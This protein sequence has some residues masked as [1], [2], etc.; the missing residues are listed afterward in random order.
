MATVPYLDTVNS[1]PNNKNLPDLWCTLEFSNATEDRI[2]LGSPACYREL[3]E[4]TIVFV[5]R[6]GR[7]DDAVIDAAEIA[8]KEFFHVNKRVQ[9][10]GT[11]P[12]EYG[13]LTLDAAGPPNTDATENGNWFLGSVSCPY[14][15]DTVRGT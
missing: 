10:V 13:D 14:V 1:I 4:V 15:F 6:S 11:D 12:P 8:R 7:Q 3:G 2:S 9:L 5:G